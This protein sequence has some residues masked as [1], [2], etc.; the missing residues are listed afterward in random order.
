MHDVVSQNDEINK[1]EARKNAKLQ[2]P[3]LL[4][5]ETEEIIHHNEHGDYDEEGPFEIESAEYH[6]ID[7]IN[8]SAKVNGIANASILAQQNFEY[9]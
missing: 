3:E 4:K 5:P 2:R 7:S 8:G 1:Q 6:Q 9:E